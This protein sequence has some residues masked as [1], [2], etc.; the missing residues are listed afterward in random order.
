MN[1]ALVALALFV[2]GLLG[3]TFRR[4]ALIVLLCFELM[5]NASGLLLV[6]FGSLQKS[7]L[8]QVL[9]LFVVIFAACEVALGLSLFLFAYRV[10]KTSDL[11]EFSELKW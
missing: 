9:Y 1:P 7:A 6:Y 11:D 5:L 4:D 10:K 2:I 3:L 8:G